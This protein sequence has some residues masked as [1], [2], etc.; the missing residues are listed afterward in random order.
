M[1]KIIPLAAIGLGTLSLQAEEQHF[2][3]CL[4]A[5]D[6]QVYP[7]TD[8]IKGVRLSI[9]GENQSL[10]GLDF[11]FA[12]V[13]DG[14]MKGAQLSFI[15][16]T[17]QEVKGVQWSWLYSGADKGVTGWSGAWVNWGGGDL[18]G[19]GT[20]LLNWNEGE[21]TGVQWGFANVS[22]RNV[23]GVQVG[24]VNVTDS[25]SGLQFGFVNYCE[26]GVKALQ[27]GLV[28]IMDN[29]DLYPVFPFVNW[30]F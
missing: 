25:L 2:N 8:S 1:K 10:T 5:P 17:A 27:V 15:F 13:L 23:T 11:G 9:Y 18:L 4:W 21:V 6:L 20:G 22:E 7:T 30:Q 19:L 14:E 26:N 29:S 12:N 28:N 16:G 3:A 24:F